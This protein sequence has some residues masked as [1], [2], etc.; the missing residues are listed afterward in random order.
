[1]SAGLLLKSV[2]KEGAIMGGSGDGLLEKQ[3]EGRIVPAPRKDAV[4]QKKG[5][6]MFVDAHIVGEMEIS[7]LDKSERSSKGKKKKTRKT[8]ETDVQ[9]SIHVNEKLIPYCKF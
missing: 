4:V 5:N 3:T 2:V 7:S 9:L 8:N 1:M 6:G